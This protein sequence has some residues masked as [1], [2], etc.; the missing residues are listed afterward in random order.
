MLF[1]PQLHRVYSFLDYIMGGCQ[2]H[3]TVSPVANANFFLSNKESI[4]CLLMHAHFC[5]LHLLFPSYSAASLNSHSIYITLSDHPGWLASAFSFPQSVNMNHCC[6]TNV[7]LEA[8]AWMNSILYPSLDSQYHPQ[9][10]KII[11]NKY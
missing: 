9:Q 7:K 11:M 2:I 1:V 10:Q 4:L 3:F 6:S 5:P 8:T